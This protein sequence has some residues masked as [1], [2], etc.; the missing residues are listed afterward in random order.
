MWNGRATSA[1]AFAHGA[2]GMMRYLLLIAVTAL[3]AFGFATPA[4][5]GPKAQLPAS[6]RITVI[7]KN[8]D[9]P[10]LNHNGIATRGFAEG[11]WI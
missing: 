4:Q 6:S 1:L 10:R 3:A 2:T 11:Q 8:S 5:W 9:H 7:T